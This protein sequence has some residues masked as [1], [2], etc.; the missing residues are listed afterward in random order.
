MS[1]VRKGPIF[2]DSKLTVCVQFFLPVS[3]TMAMAG[4]ITWIVGLLALSRRLNDVP[5]ASIGISLVAI[6]VILLLV[7]IF[8]YV[9]LGIILNQEED[10]DD[11]TP[12]ERARNEGGN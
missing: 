5:S 11:E 6:P 2:R 4:V 12:T 8:W 3:F 10:P 7:G 1:S 9:F